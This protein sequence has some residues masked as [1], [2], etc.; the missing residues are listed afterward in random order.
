[1]LAIDDTNYA[2]IHQTLENYLFG[3]KSAQDVI[4][5]LETFGIERRET[6][7]VLQTI[8]ETFHPTEATPDNDL[9]DAAMMILS[10]KGINKKNTPGGID[11]NPLIMQREVKKNGRGVIIPTFKGPVP[12]FTNLEGFIPNIINVTPVTNLFPLLGI[13]PPNPQKKTPTEVSY[14]LSYLS[15]FSYRQQVYFHYN[16]KQF[17]E[18]YA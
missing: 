2:Q 16:S 11:M 14:N 9:E 12:D 10:A 7:F 17:E 8:S 5:V 6:E 1:M 3:S 18:I 13:A 15:C 4:G